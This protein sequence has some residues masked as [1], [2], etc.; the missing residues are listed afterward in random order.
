[1]RR[2]NILYCISN[3]YTKYCCVSMYSLLA[4]NIDA[5]FCVN[6]FTDYIS[7]RNRKL[8]TNVTRTFDAE[9]KIHLIDDEKVSGLN[10]KWS[11]YAWYRLFVTD[12]IAQSIDRILYLDCDTIVNANIT[13]LFKLS[14]KDKMLAAVPDIMDVDPHT[15]ERLRY[16]PQKGYF[17]S[18][19]LMINCDYFRQKNLSKKIPEFARRHSNILKFP[20]QDALNIFAKDAKI[21]LPLKYGVLS[22]F[23]AESFIKKYPLQVIDSLENPLII[24]YAGCAPWIIEH[25]SHI[26][27]PIYWKYANKIKTVKPKHAPKGIALIK[28]YLIMFLSHF[29][30]PGFRY[31]RI[32]KASISEAKQYINSVLAK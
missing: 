7:N 17:C 29:H 30:I 16:T 9:L 27:S 19:I 14:L 8:L 24:H 32:K 6:I 26:H 10:L 21:V 28:L 22:W 5:K 12:Y 4:N 11:K 2:L 18:G 23:N 20:D 15:F 13:G 31:N 25:D 3:N 1:M